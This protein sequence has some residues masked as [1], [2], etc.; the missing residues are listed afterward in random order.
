MINMSECFSMIGQNG[1][2]DVA[3][4]LGLQ[5]IDSSMPEISIPIYGPFFMKILMGQ[6]AG[7][8][9][10]HIEEASALQQLSKNC[11]TVAVTLNICEMDILTLIGAVLSFTPNT[12]MNCFLNLTAVD[13]MNITADMVPLIAEAAGVPVPDAIIDGLE[14]YEE[15]LTDI[16]NGLFDMLVNKIDEDM[17]ANGIA[18]HSFED[19]FALYQEVKESG[20]LMEMRRYREAI[21]AF[22]L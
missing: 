21:G 16:L 7:F 17:S 4:S 9:C 11:G 15:F 2:M 14:D 22:V 13:L 3:S 8:I 19:L 12:G 6:N 1:C 18:V 10:S 5:G 20:E